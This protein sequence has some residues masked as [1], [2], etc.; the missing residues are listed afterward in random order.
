MSDTE[1][2]TGRA[3]SLGALEILVLGI[4]NSRNGSMG[5]VWNLRA[6]HSKVTSVIFIMEK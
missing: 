3:S 2:L 6:P 4:V 1:T 5:V